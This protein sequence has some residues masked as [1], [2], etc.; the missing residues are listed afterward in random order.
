M[1][2]WTVNLLAGMCL[3]GGFAWVVTPRD[4]SRAITP[5]AADAGV[6]APAVSE[7]PPAPPVETAAQA[8][9]RGAA[10][11]VC[12]GALLDRR[13]AP[14]VGLT[15]HRGVVNAIKDDNPLQLRA[16]RGE[17]DTGWVVGYGH[18]A[19]AS[20]GAT[21]TT[22]DAE[23]LLRADL[24]VIEAAVR[25]GVETPLH[26]NEFSALVHAGHTLGVETVLA[27]ATVVRLNLGDR[28]AA[29]RQ[30]GRLGARS[31]AEEAE[32][33]AAALG[34]RWRALFECDRRV[35]FRAASPPSND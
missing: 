21:I 25:S 16:R 30:L 28:E 32:A 14:F 10:V 15:T 22:G 7:T 33:E 6:L 17:G 20:A 26:I 23:R 12:D 2:R 19:T 18:T 5:S 11:V 35:R 24:A 13:P 1:A 29:G 9:A 27:H 31:D 34:A 8:R 3:A 4:E